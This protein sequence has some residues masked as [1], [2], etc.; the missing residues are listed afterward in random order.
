[1]D[2]TKAFPSINALPTDRTTV[3]KAALL[4]L[5]LGTGILLTA[6]FASPDLLHNAAHDSRHSLAFPCH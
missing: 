5:V 2:T 3:A 6:G 1:M 4:A